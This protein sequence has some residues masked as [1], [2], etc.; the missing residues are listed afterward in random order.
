MSTLY[1]V[2]EYCYCSDW[3]LWLVWWQL[4]FC[5]ILIWKHP[6]IVR[7]NNSH[8]DLFEIRRDRIRQLT[9]HWIDNQ[10]RSSKSFESVFQTGII[11]T[12]NRLEVAIEFLSP[13]GIRIHLLNIHQIVSK[14]TKNYDY[15]A[16]ATVWDNYKVIRTDWS[17]FG[18]WTPSGIQMVLPTWTHWKIPW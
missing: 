17:C 8:F 7:K 5:R 13:F 2:E 14:I 10:R 16:V 6:W 15:P 4:G 9:V 12:G 3:F 1:C 11:I 18:Y